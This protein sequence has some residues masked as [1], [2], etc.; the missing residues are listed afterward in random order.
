M[1]YLVQDF[2]LLQRDGVNLIQ[3]IQAG[4]ILPVALN[5]V[6]DV[7]FSRIT[8]Q[9]DI[10]IVYFVLF[11]DGLNHIVRQSVGLARS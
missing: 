8:L 6:N 2:Q 9:T 10:G 4:N 7:V 3:C 11:Q 5:D 1:I